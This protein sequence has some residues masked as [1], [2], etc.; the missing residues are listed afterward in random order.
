MRSIIWFCA[1]ACAII[2]SLLCWAAFGLVDVTAA[3]AEGSSS[4]ITAIVPGSEALLRMLIGLADDV[5]EGLIFVMWLAGCGFALGGAWLVS[6]VLGALGPA[7][8]ARDW[9][10]PDPRDI[11]PPPRPIPLPGSTA[12]DVL[13]RLARRGVRSSDDTRP[14]NPNT[15]I[16]T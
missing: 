12:N 11:E 15:R 14:R 16:Q 10:Q 1:W 4:I 8:M 2:W 9:S 5:G 3:L 13:D 6:Q 7:P